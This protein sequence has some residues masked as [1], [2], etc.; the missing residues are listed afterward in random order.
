MSVGRLLKMFPW[1]INTNV[2][3]YGFLKLKGFQSPLTSFKPETILNIMLISR[4]H[5]FGARLIAL[6]LQL[7]F[8][9][10]SI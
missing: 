9:N 6:L 1:E 8:D 3:D 7:Q 5:T 4:E 10:K 2:M